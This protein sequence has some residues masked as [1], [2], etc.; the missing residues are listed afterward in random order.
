VE[1]AKDQSGI[2]TDLPV[3]LVPFDKLVKQI[4]RKVGQV[5]HRS[6]H[7]GFGA[8]SCSGLR[9]CAALVVSGRGFW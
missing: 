3:D 4:G 5:T 9:A 8:G 1:E 2:N 6:T 7:E